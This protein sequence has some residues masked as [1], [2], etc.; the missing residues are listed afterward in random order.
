ML[1]QDKVM[2]ISNIGC[3]ITY[4]NAIVNKCYINHGDPQTVSRTYDHARGFEDAL[5]N[6]NELKNL[7][8]NSN[9]NCC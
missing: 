5:E 1:D 9:M 8:S 4:V 6:F 2:K 3:D 7:R